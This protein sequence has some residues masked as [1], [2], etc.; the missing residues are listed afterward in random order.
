MGK[1]LKQFID[2]SQTVSHM[3]H[4]SLEGPGAQIELKAIFKEFNL[5]KAGC[6][7]AVASIADAV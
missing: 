5:I 2:A 3:G 6:D 7:S 1:H 4:R